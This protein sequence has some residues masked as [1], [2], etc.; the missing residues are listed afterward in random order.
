[1]RSLKHFNFAAPGLSSIYN[2]ICETKRLAVVIYSAILL[3][4]AGENLILYQ[5]Q[6]PGLVA[7]DLN[8]TDSNLS[9]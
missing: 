9:Q 8:N 7:E 5:L 1:L 4:G 3:R 6:V 2:A